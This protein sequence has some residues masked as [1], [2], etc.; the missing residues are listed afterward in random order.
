MHRLLSL[1]ISFV[2]NKR[3]STIENKQRCTT[4]WNILMTQWLYLHYFTQDSQRNFKSEHTME[5]EGKLSKMIDSQK[6]DFFPGLHMAVA[7]AQFQPWHKGNSQGNLAL[8]EVYWYR[9]GLIGN[10][11]V[12]TIDEI[13]TV[14][15]AEL[16]SNGSLKQQTANSTLCATRVGLA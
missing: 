2:C 15:K 14:A 5:L 16:P 10:Y 13:W 1:W 12:K 8:R 9:I 11:I 7:A 3:G 6:R 4:R